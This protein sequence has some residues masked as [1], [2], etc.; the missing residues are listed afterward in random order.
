MSVRQYRKISNAL[1]FIFADD[2]LV[3]NN[4]MP[5]LVYTSRSTS[6]NDAVPKR[7]SRGFSAPWL[8]L[9]WRNGVFAYLHYHSHRAYRSASA[10]ATRGLAFRRRCGEEA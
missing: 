3:P 7:P 10:P 6:A 9:D 5:F 4:P 1:T 2:V 8:V